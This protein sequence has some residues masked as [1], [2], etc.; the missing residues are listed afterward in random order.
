MITFPVSD[1]SS[2]FLVCNWHADH[3]INYRRR[4]SDRFDGETDYFSVSNRRLHFLLFRVAKLIWVARWCS[5]I[6]SKFFVLK[7]HHEFQQ[8]SRLSK[9]GN[10]CE[11]VTEWF[12]PQYLTS[13]QI[14][15]TLKILRVFLEIENIS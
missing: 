2:T 10:F 8:I 6:C 11:I 3:S 1:K 7:L 12:F 9:T 5:S 13:F 14:S 15:F 4:E